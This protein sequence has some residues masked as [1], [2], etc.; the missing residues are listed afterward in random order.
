MT[1]NHAGNSEAPYHPSPRLARRATW[2][3]RRMTLAS[4]LAGL[5]L[6]A[7]AGPSQAQG[8][9]GAVPPRTLD[10]EA[11][12]SVILLGTGVPLPNP[13]RS[14]ACTAVL[15]GARVFLVD[16]GRNCIVTLAQAGIQAI[17]G[18][19]YTHYHSD[20]FAGLG[21]ILLNLG[22]A[23]L[24]RSIPVHGP[25]GARQM[26]DGMLAFYRLDLDYRIAHHGEKFSAASMTPAVTEHQP[27]T[28]L[29]EDGLK[30]G[31][32]SVC[33]EPIE[34]AVGYRFEYRG[35]SVVISGDTRVCP[36]YAEGARGADLLVSEVENAQLFQTALAM[37]RGTN[38]A[39]QVEMIQEGMEY[40]AESLALARMAQEAGVKKLA[41]THLFP[42]IAATDAAEALFIRGMSDLYSGPIIVGR[43][44]M[45]ITP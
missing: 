27:G 13:S 8:L 26:V 9:S 5:A 20:H 35:Q 40:H 16:T 3:P 22:I 30:V 15:A 18:I 23:G 34:P 29:E 19:F 24:D 28:V 38:N 6:L 37:A 33:H 1:Q 32:F 45:E 4:L 11:G 7:S 21:E 41:L 17:D 14:A 42:S 44:G 25:A 12:L 39:R 36:A 43:D 2:C 31:M 10:P